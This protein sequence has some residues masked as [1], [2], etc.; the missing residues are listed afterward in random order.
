MKSNDSLRRILTRT[1]PYWDAD[2]TRP[3]VRLGFSK[4]LQCRTP[5]LG[6]EVYSS[7][8]VEKIV[9]HTCKARSCS[10]C[11]Y[12]ATAQWQ[13]E[14]WAALPDV[15]YKGITFTMPDVFWPLFRDNPHLVLQ[16][17]ETPQ[18]FDDGW[19]GLS[20][21]EKSR[22]RPRTQRDSAQ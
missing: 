13:R 6:A 15:P 10:S 8:N 16:G 12:R 9:Y 19:R 2:K 4:A 21:V 11:G 18:S 1:R 3:E 5:A 22:R 20:C 7:E 14:R 17:R